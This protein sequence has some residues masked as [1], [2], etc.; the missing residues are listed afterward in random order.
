MVGI[1]ST[2]DWVIPQ[3]FQGM[4]TEVTVAESS[5]LRLSSRGSSPFLR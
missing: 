5:V 3:E 2:V 4:S 1:F